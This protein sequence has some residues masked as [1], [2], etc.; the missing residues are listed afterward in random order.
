MKAGEPADWLDVLPGR[1]NSNKLRT[2][3]IAEPGRERRTAT[4]PL[5]KAASL[6]FSEV[7]QSKKR[8][9]VTGIASTRHNCEQI[10]RLNL[11]RITNVSLAMQLGQSKIIKDKQGLVPHSR[12]KSQSSRAA[13]AAGQARPAWVS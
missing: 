10:I 6:S 9:K 3:G 5:F 2:A 13:W 1:V 7:E 11:Q 8:K 12:R 4:N